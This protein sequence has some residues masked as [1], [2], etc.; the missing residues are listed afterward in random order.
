MSVDVNAPDFSE[1]FNK[2]DA[3]V[4]VIGQGFVG[5][6]MREYFARHGMRVVAYDKYRPEHGTLADVVKQSDVIFV[7]VPTPM[8]PTGECYTGIVVEV[9][10]D[11]ISATASIGRPGD[12]F[13]VCIKSTVPPGFTAQ[14][15]RQFP[16]LRITFS[17][18]YLTEKHALHDM[19]TG[20]RV[21][22]GGDDDDT[23]VV[24]RFFLEADRRRV[25]EGKLL[26]VATRDPAVAEMAKLFANGLLSAKVM[27]CNE[28]QR[29][30]QAMGIDYEETRAVTCLDSRIGASHTRVPGPD[31]FHAIGGHC[32]P[33][34]LN[35]LKH[36]ASVAGTG[37]RI[38][39]ALLQRNDDLREPTGRD[40][41]QMAGRAVIDK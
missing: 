26:L 7:C 16:T 25:D 27:F 33:K 1:R 35:D 2:E 37:E 5:G 17:P 29:L 18:E 38:F 41:E 19:L 10:N 8:R 30:C 11:I 3:V 22:V 23:R 13:V 9:L 34:D 31:G 24:L 36:L 15:Q 4:G 6:T 28:V 32:L 40:W 21:V 39:T 14:M 20:S 12:T